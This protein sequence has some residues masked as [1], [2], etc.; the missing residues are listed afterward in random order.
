MKK[1]I[2][3]MLLVLVMMVGLFPVSALAADEAQSCSTMFC[4]LPYGHEGDCEI[5]FPDQGEGGIKDPEPSPVPEQE[6]TE[7]PD[8]VAAQAVI[9]L[10]AAIGEVSLESEAAIAA[11]DTAYRALSEAQQ[12]L[13]T[14]L[15]VL[16]AAK[17]AYGALFEPEEIAT[18]HT[19]IYDNSS[20]ADTRWPSDTEY[21]KKIRIDKAVDVKDY[22]W[23]GDTCTVTLA[24]GTSST[25]TVKLRFTSTNNVS[26]T[27]D[28]KTATGAAVSFDVVLVNGTKTVEMSIVANGVEV[29]KT[30]I[31]VVEG[32]ET[33]TVIEPESVSLSETSLSMAIGETKDISAS[34]L[35]D[36]ANDKTLTWSSSNGA[37][38][39]YESGKI[40]ARGAGTATITATSVNGKSAS[41]TVTVAPNKPAANATV[42]VT[43]S[44][45]GKLALANTPVTVK[46]Y[47]SDGVLTYDEAMLATHEAHCPAGPDGFAINYSSGWVYKLW[48][49]STSNLLFFNNDS[50]LGAFL[51]D[52][53]NVVAAGDSL[54]AAVLMYEEAYKDW[55]NIFD[56]KALTVKAGQEFELTLSGFEGASH[57]ANYTLSAVSG[58]QI[59]FW[60]GEFEAIEG[61]LTDA[62]GK[63]SL[64]ISEPG[65]YIISAYN[66]ATNAPLMAPYCVVTVEAAE[67]VEPDEP[68]GTK[69]YVTISSGEGQLLVVNEA[70]TVTDTDNDGVLT[71]HDALVVLHEKHGKVYS[72]V[73]STYD[74]FVQTLWSIETGGSA[75]FFSNDATIPCSVSAYEVESGYRL[76]AAILQ[77]ALYWSDWY[78]SF[79]KRYVSVDAGE[80]FT[81]SLTGYS[82]FMSM[83]GGAGAIAI[84][85][86]NIGVYEDEFVDLGVDTDSDGKVSLSFDTAGS[87]IVTAQGTVWDD[88]MYVECPV[89][90]PY[91]F[92]TVNAPE[93]T[94]VPVSSIS[95]DKTTASITV[96]ATETITATVS[97]DNATDKT[98][99][100]SS[101]DEAVVTVENGVVTAVAAGTATIT[102]KAGD[103]SA[104][105]TVTVEAAEIA[106]TKVELNKT[107]LE[108]EIGASETLTASVTPE[109]AT[110]KVVSWTSSDAS[111]ASVSDSGLVTAVAAGTATITATVGDKS[112]ECTVTVN[113]AKVK[114]YF[115]ALKFRAGTTTSSAELELIPAFSPEVREYTLIVPDNKTT[116][117]VWA[118]CAEGQTG[119]I[120]A[121]YKNTSNSSKSVTV[122]SGNTSGASLSSILK[123]GFGGNSI[124]ITVGNEEACTVTIVRKAT[125]SGLALSSGSDYT[126]VLDPEFNADKTEY[127]A[128]V[129]Y[130][131]PVTVATNGKYTG[132]VVTIN[133][134]ANTEITP[135]WTGLKSE[136][137]IVVSGGTANP[138]VV[139]NTYKVKLDQ[140]ATAIEIQ[141]PPTKTEY[142]AG[143]K[144]DA[145]GLTL[146]A[147]Y[148]DGSTEIIE[149]GRYSYIP[150]KAMDPGVSEIEVSFDGLTVKQAIT[151][152][153]DFEGTGTQDDPY[154]MKTADNLVRLSEMVADGVSFEGMY[155]KMAND[156]TLPTDWTPLGT[157]LTKP[158]SGNFDGGNNLLTVPAGGLPLI[159]TPVKASLCNL[160]VYGSQIAGFG[161]VNGYTNDQ[162]YRPA[163]TIDNVT[164]T[165]GTQTLQSGFIGG[166]ASGQ[167]TVIIK[168]STVEKGVTIGYGKDQKYIGSFGGEY[169][170]S[171][172]NCVSYATV[173]GTDFVGGIM[174]CKGQSIGTCEIIN[175]QFYGSVVA[176]GNYVGGIAGHGYGGN[177]I[178]GMASAPNTPLVTISGCV[179][180]G[181]VSGVDYVGG[182]LG[183]ESG[184]V[185]AWENGPGYIQNNSFTGTVSG[186]NYVGGVI[187]YMRS[188]N[189]YTVISGNYYSSAAKGIGSVEY[190]DTNCETHETESG[191]T[192]INTANGV[193]GLP[194]IQYNS[195]RAN[196]NRSDDPMGA[197]AAKLCYSDKDIAPVAVELEISGNYKTEY[198]VGDELDLSGIVLTVKYNKGDP[199][200]IE[201]KDVTISGYDKTKV[202]EQNLT[203]SYEGLDAFVTVT[204]KNAT[205]EITVSVSI[206]ACSIHGDGGTQHT[207][208]AGNLS[209]WASGSYTLEGD[210]TA[211]DAI[212]KCLDENG[213]SYS[214]PTG[215]YIKA[216][217][218]LAEFTNGDFS[219]WMYTLNG[220]HPVYGVSEQML[221]DKD[222]IVVHYTDNYPVD[223]GMGTPTDTS[224]VTAV[225]KLIKEIGTVTLDS[226]AK[227][228]AA[229]KAYDALSYADKQKVSNYST[230][231]AAEEQFKKFK[232]ADDKEK[233]EEVIALING[234]GKYSEKYEDNVKAARKAYD[235][236]SEDQKK[237]VTNY[238]LL[239][240]AEKLIA[241][242]GDLEA[243]ENVERLIRLI[244]KKV[245]L[246]S[247][248]KIE[249]ARKAY[250]LLT[251]KQKNL[252]DNYK[253]L[254]AAEEA[255]AQLEKLEDVKDIV[256][257]TGEHMEKLGTPTVADVGGE[258]MAL[259]LTRNGAEVADDYYDDV[260]KFVKENINENGQL[261]RAKSTENSRLILSLTAMGKDVTNVG[262]HNL[263]EGLTDMDFLNKQGING[264]IWA[265]I[266][267][268][269]GNYPV[270]EGNVSRAGLVDTILDAQ[271]NDGGWA[272]SGEISDADMT[273]MAL[274]ALAPYVE[275]NKEVKKAVEKTLETLSK[276]QNA[277]G[278]FGSI[279]GSSSE[280]CAQIIVALSA[281][282][283]DADTDPRFIKN[284]ISL[285]DALC[286]FYVEGGGFSHT[287]GGKLNGMATE[288]AYYALTAYFRMRDGKTALYDMTDVVDKGGDK[289]APSPS[290]KAEKPS[291]SPENKAETKNESSS[292]GFFK[293]LK[294]LF[295]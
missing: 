113:A 261:H 74:L 127:K 69:V 253:D 158:F 34:V 156:I 236:L 206:L 179:C 89:I 100:W 150:D 142:K 33:P 174:G 120:K 164:L 274:T 186:N 21:V 27:I 180:A 115:S 35:P 270:P 265:L 192:Y 48:G 262:G 233:S 257:L 5:S 209:T 88:M 160:K 293:W 67:A 227:I 98:V 28:G 259:G 25:A 201:L 66:N 46:D 112:A 126:A 292:G 72:A 200:T 267:F 39:N 129:P 212:K 122:K 218:G 14:N 215:N 159:G 79:D 169:N 86:A 82:A 37:V 213:F 92:V 163:I 238:D 9:D 175:C 17:L 65:E 264:P 119:T 44:N 193:A 235:S 16:D 273:G 195:W 245:S 107:S 176:S 211:W 59:G 153:T 124:S 231:T 19:T 38:A 226:K 49:E 222:V 188:L 110:N 165:A 268:D 266:A 154:L 77:D 105:C 275:D 155:I 240:Q 241:D 146:K 134:A 197:D 147:T 149:K 52:K 263:L 278:T 68:S 80:E 94:V 281:L 185:Q 26:V 254:E 53:N 2:L 283:I 87:Y 130:D 256:K 75:M 251:E 183:A 258:W 184:V 91:C 228:E 203:V 295:S 81:L 116:V 143:D 117:A 288:Q 57:G 162:S 219:G 269:S 24:S 272:L 173:Y 12:A 141:T 207:L 29:K 11:A 205:K 125:L 229:R 166:Y 22:E 108:L 15:D 73:E 285:L 51:T 54:Y 286:S 7:N 221:K 137:E 60:D 225:E 118:T 199:K 41:C 208:T 145:T 220:V 284:G 167:N 178:G 202:G 45:R 31:L 104:T 243:A 282:G 191:A 42:N 83:D 131:K 3:S 144:F 171:I 70:V 58:A 271:L 291:P 140:C 106:V 136:I 109:D 170:G 32:A 216:I 114:E 62:E 260:V 111:I 247:K 43:I 217:N 242:K 246:D 289:L 47:N 6:P 10:I 18:S 190:V 189:K 132:S 194:S 93:V 223:D 64:S 85:S 290:P 161:V 280:S 230:L 97:P 50:P 78:S 204:V 248:Q 63:V 152:S 234:I 276:M 214:N 277:D 96:G 250:D 138:T 4:V 71:F 61:K 239:V 168:N 123:V 177:Y 84:P 135:T 287:P 23:S 103:K 148:S 210:V 157:S 182:I 172:I 237:L 8:Q 187:G 95:L 101:S 20:G 244:G 249:L 40:V 76:H 224:N 55:Y 279:D 255:F 196:H 36:N 90:P 133:G 151:M 294:K 1:R 121:A 13:V 99:T 30:I 139:S 102:A 198:I 128:R 56:K 252:V 181:S 232:D